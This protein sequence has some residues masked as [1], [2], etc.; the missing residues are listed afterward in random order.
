MVS[1]H[2]ALVEVQPCLFKAEKSRDVLISSPK[3]S[4]VPH[5]LTRC[6][7]LCIMQLH[8]TVYYAAGHSHEQP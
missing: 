2:I 7:T 5:S 3:L 6:I 1:C 8:N 4:L